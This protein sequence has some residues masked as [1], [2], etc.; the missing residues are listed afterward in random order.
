MRVQSATSISRQFA[1]VGLAALFGLCACVAA[2]QFGEPTTKKLIFAAA[3]PLVPLI[4]WITRQPR[5]VLMFLWILLLPY[6]RMYYWFDG[7]VGDHGPHGPYVIPTDVILAALFGLWAYE[8]GVLKRPLRP[9]GPRLELWLLPFG[10]MCLLSSLGA[11]HMSWGLFELLRLG[12][13][14]AIIIY[15]RFNVT[16]R[17]VC[18]CVVA[19][20]CSLCAQSGVAMLQMALRSTAGVLGTAALVTVFD[21]DYA[22]VGRVTHLIFAVGMIVILFAPDTSNKRMDD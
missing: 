6:N 9:A 17:E 7:L 21:S 18:V 19:L 16:R 22:R 4:C 8:L 14:A 15:I 11:P 5:S 20:L 12:K 13:V 2:V 10:L 1:S 3:V